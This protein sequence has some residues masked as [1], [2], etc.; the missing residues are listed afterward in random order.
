M[1]FRRFFLIYLAFVIG[2]QAQEKSP[3]PVK[4]VIFLIGDGMGF[5]QLGLFLLY[6]KYAPHS[7]YE[8]KQTTLEKILHTGELGYA[9][10]ESY[11]VLVSDSA[12]SAT[13]FATG[14]MALSETIGLDHHGNPVETILEMAIRLKK[15]TGL[16]SDTR[17]S[18]AT[19]AAFAAHQTH[20][21]KENEIAVDLLKSNAD[22]L[23]SGGLRYWVPNQ[24]NLSTAEAERFQAEYQIPFLPQSKRKD[25]R[26]LL[27]EAKNQGY[28]LAFSQAQLQSATGRKVLGLFA[29]SV[30]PDGIQEHL[31]KDKRTRTIPTLPEMT[32][33]A[34]EILSQNERGFFLMVEAGQI[35]WAGH[36]ND[37]GRLL[38]EMI[39]FNATLDTLYQWMRDREDTL[40][41]ISADHET[42]GFGF[43]YSSRNVPSPVPLSS[44]AFQQ[45]PFRPQYNFGHATILDRL[46]Q[47]TLS[48]E[49]LFGRFDQLPKAERTPVA[50]ATLVNTHTR[51][52]ITVEEAK[53]IL[54]TEPNA[55]RLAGHEYLSLEEVPKIEDFKEF[56]VYGNDS[57][58][59]L[60]G[61]VVSKYQNV[62]WSTGTHTHTPVPLITFGPSHVTAPFGR[63]L[64]TT[65]WAKLAKKVLESY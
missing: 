45:E 22:I 15:S 61:R 1:N 48:Y 57:R 33:K 27:E 7:I 43:S 40:L 26:N 16:V 10:H 30:L 38:H 60:L 35:D 49:E 58:L 9:T 18:H 14:E 64:H 41:I 11:H 13:Q 25:T 56:Y 24:L 3:P 29:N 54:A 51:F 63:L 6:S 32:Q 5:Q 37:A 12:S 34:L 21:S 8:G 17:I 59:C 36:D 53:T 44:G 2:L 46:Y 28:Q 31:E 65:E 19:P 42:G 39:K 23:F 55:Y 20:R 47:Q 4:N 50:L 52:P 62:V